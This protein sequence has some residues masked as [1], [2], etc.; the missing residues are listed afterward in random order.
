MLDKLFD[1][2]DKKRDSKITI[3]EYGVYG[4]REVEAVYSDSTIPAVDIL[5]LTKTYI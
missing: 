3:T 5:S 2:L 4:T 1:R